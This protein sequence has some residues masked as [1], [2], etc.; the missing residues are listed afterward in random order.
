MSTPLPRPRTTPAGGGIR[1]FAGAAEEPRSR[2][3]TD[4]ILLLVSLIG[5]V[6]ASGTRHTRL[7][8]DLDRLVDRAP[9][10]LSSV[11][12]ALVVQLVVLALVTVGAAG[13][14]RR[15]SLL[16][17]LLVAAIL[18]AAGELIV[19]RLGGPHWSLGPALLVVAVAVV[20]GASPHL[21]RPLRGVGRWS[22]SLGILG[23][24]L[25]GTSPASTI[26]AGFL[27]ALAAATIVHL[28]LGSCRGRPGVDDIARVLDELGIDAATVGVANRQLTGVFV[29]DAVD[30]D[31]RRMTVKVYG[32]D[33]HDTQLVT[34]IWRTVWYRDTDAPTF[35]DRRHQAEHEALVTLLAAQ[36]GIRTQRVIVVASTERDDVVLV[37]QATDASA[38]IAGRW[39][40]A[41]AAHAWS[42]LA[43]LHSGRIAHGQLDDD[44]LTLA[45]DDVVGLVDF[46][47]AV[48]DPRPNQL[49]SDHAQLLV[50]T[51]L[52]LGPG[53]AVEV[54]GRV[55]GADQLAHTLAHLQPPLLTPAQRRALRRDVIDLDELRTAAAAAVGVEAPALRPIRR[56]TWRSALEVVLLVV[57][58]VA[59]W[60][61][62][63]G[64][65]LRALFG[66]LA[67]ASSWLVLAGFLL[68]QVPRVSQ[69]CS[70]LG[71]A[72]TKVPAG[73]VYALQLTSSYLSLAVPSSA[74]RIAVGV[75]FFQRRGLSAG[76]ALTV[77]A[78]DG[79]TQWVVQGGLL[80]ATLL[81]S[82][83]NLDLDLGGTVATGLRILVVIVVAAVVVAGL[84][85]AVSRRAR[86]L[87]TTR[88]RAQAIESAD[89]VRGLASPRRLALLVGGN[90]ATE[91]L[92]VLTLTTF[93]GALG[94][95]VSPVELLVVLVSV[96]LIAS[97]VPIPG[98]IGI[99]ETGL[100]LGLV[101]MGVQEDAAFTVVLLYRLSTF[102]LPPI[103]GYA[104]QRW[105][106][107]NGHL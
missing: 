47:A 59:L 85:L 35:A 91:I 9:D 98:G 31:G 107:R 8:A 5:L 45:G 55:L 63:G 39:T 49:A 97:V 80:A 70:T 10:Q 32:R 1:L 33:A 87:V 101:G 20:V 93:A 89:V 62:L 46:R 66:E 95:Y 34:N 26:L 16:R 72:P 71:A 102:Y 13:L 78:I 75:R 60:T 38:P 15:V 69:M 96:S 6:L 25:L 27:G 12:W 22:I 44:R 54:A 11:W 52:A 83:V 88:V 28:A 58:F 82:T 18:A 104:A 53:T 48:M 73:P 40:V 76:S 99:V 67:H 106:V 37:L 64:L 61:G 86:A 3:A 29:V 4:G 68:A 50:A 90:V 51:A 79:L 42:M 92:F 36:A 43:T 57:A 30:T 74:G 103:W 2:R 77:G 105:L 100:V 19:T 7:S 81:L 56:V 14:A 84:A 65:D 94:Y 21:A 17:D 41:S 24:L 23:T